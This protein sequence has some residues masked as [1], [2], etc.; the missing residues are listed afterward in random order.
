M[1]GKAD[2]IQGRGTH[3]PVVDQKLK[4]YSGEGEKDEPS[5]PASFNLVPLQL[6]VVDVTEEE[7][8]CDLL[9]LVL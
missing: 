7:S 9:C 1:I 8:L 4:G 5:H 6:P 2:E 3:K